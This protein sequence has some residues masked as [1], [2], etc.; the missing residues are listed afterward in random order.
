[1]GFCWKQIAE[2]TEQGPQGGFRRSVVDF[3]FIEL[4]KSKST[5]ACS[6]SSLLASAQE[7]FDE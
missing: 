3:V 2:Q 6:V 1:L 4:G 5:G 7:S